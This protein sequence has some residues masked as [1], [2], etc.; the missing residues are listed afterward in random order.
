LEAFNLELARA[1]ELR[2]AEVRRE[3]EKERRQHRLFMTGL[4]LGFVVVI[5]M[6]SAAVVLGMQGQPELAGVLATLTIAV[7]TVFVLRKHDPQSVKLVSEAAIRMA[8]RTSISSA[9][10]SHGTPALPATQSQHSG[11]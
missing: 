4:I 11:H 3:E 1:H 7:A 6:S 10:P 9:D 5:V 8:S 2:L